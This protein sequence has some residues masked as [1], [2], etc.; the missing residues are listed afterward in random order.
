M[1][2]ARERLYFTADRIRLV[3]DG[4]P[5]AAFLYAALGDEIPDSAATKFGLVNGR[6]KMPAKGKR[7][8][9]AE[10]LLGSSTLPSTIVIND[11]RSAQLGEVVT[12]AHKASGLTVDAWNALPNDQREDLLK[13]TIEAMR[14]QQPATPPVPPPAPN[15]PPRPAKPKQAAASKAEQKPANKEQAPPANKEQ[16]AP[17]NKGG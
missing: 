10:T 3:R 9:N 8:D 2:H 6:L 16:P 4:D 15:R 7:D 14:A 12:E 17:E 13:T 5:K 1:Q 11:A